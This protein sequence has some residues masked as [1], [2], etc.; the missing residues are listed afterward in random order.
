MDKYI[1]DNRGE[2][3]EGLVDATVN[4]AIAYAYQE[5]NPNQ[6][7]MTMGVMDAME[8]N[9]RKSKA[10]QQIRDHP[11]VRDALGQPRVMSVH[12]TEP[13]PEPVEYQP[14]SR[15]SSPAQLSPGMHLVDMPSPGTTR[16]GKLIYYTCPN[17][18]GQAG[19]SHKARLDHGSCGV[20]QGDRRE[21]NS[22]HG[23]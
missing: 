19:E 2:Y 17:K 4:C 13:V 18:A 1:R 5:N 15:P 23:L 20:Q 11:R 10:M 16:E 9:S 12:Q 8:V 7:Y 6:E 14:L 22:Q 21:S 3:N